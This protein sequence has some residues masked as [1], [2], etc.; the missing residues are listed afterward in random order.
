MKANFK[1]ES[2]CALQFKPQEGTCCLKYLP[3]LSLRQPEPKSFYETANIPNLKYVH[4]TETFN[5]RN[6]V[7]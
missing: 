6:H 1:K 5:I 4:H 3:L 7:D 2:P